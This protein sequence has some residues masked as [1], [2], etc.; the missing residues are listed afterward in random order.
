MKLSNGMAVTKK[1]KPW[2]SATFPYR[3]KQVTALTHNCYISNIRT[4]KQQDGDDIEAVRKK[5]FNNYNLTSKVLHY[6]IIDGESE[7]Q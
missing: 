2:R 5:S 1:S 4:V 3:I 6:P 7:T